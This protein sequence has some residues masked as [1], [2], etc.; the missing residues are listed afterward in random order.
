MVKVYAV[1]P[2]VCPKCDSEMRVITIIGI[3]ILLEVFGYPVESVYETNL[4]EEEPVPVHLR[5]NCIS[6]CFK[7]FKI[8]TLKVK[9]E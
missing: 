3:S 4:L 1:D 9:A 6:L 2:F 7:P 8:K 5:H